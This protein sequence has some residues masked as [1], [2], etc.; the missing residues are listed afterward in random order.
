[1]S[2]MHKW[3]KTTYLTIKVKVNDTFF[4]KTPDLRDSSEYPFSTDAKVKIMETKFDRHTIEMDT[5]LDKPT[6]KND[7]PPY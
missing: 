5:N 3:K 6:P 1:M 4:A 2:E 7:N